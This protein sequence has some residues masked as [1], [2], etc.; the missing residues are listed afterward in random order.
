[1]AVVSPTPDRGV[2][3]I[4][5]EALSQKEPR[6]AYDYWLRK[7]GDRAM[8]HP[9]DINPAEIGRLLP[10]VALVDVL[11]ES[12]PDYFFRIE[13][14]LVQR[15]IGFRRMG[16]RLSKFKKEYG[17]VYE[18]AMRRFEAVCAEK[19][20]MA[21]TSTLTRLGRGFYTI[22]VVVLPFSQD[23]LRVDRILH[24]IGFLKR[25]IEG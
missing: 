20:P 25:P 16:Q 13:G 11:E 18:R 5:L 19:V 10:Y 12:P 14:E 4:S 15:A 6:A 2:S 17:P 22:E 24:C 8:P 21:Q 9:K 7:R 23:D 1:M 3:W